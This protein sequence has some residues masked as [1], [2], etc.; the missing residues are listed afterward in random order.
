[1][2]ISKTVFLEKDI[3]QRRLI[4]EW[5]NCKAV[6][7]VWPFVGSDWEYM[8]EQIT[9]A[10]WQ[11]L[12][13]IS[14]HT[15]VWAVLHSSIDQTEWLKKRQLLKITNAK[16]IDLN[17]ND[18]W[19]RDYGPLTVVNGKGE[20]ILADFRFNGWGEKFDAKLDDSFCQHLGKLENLTYE[21][22]NMVLE[23]GAI[24]SNG[25][26]LLLMNK[27]CVVDEK[28]NADYSQRRIEKIIRQQLNHEALWIEGIGL[29]GDDTDGHIDTIARFCNHNTVIY[30]GR[31]TQH[32]DSDA[33]QS[34]H[35]QIGR[36]AQQKNWNLFE[37]PTPVLKS[38]FE[39]RF[40]PATYTNFLVCNQQ[41]FFPIYNCAEDQ[42]ALTIA[43][44]A[45]PNHKVI[46]MDCLNLLEESGSLHCATMQLTT[47]NPSPGVNYE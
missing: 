41:V 22:H 28:R 19:I 38:Q 29:T 31:N 30:S 42:L 23:G 34:L 39:D 27:D 35:E 13:T 32:H 26:G 21:T 25:Q 40:L 17:V 37:L 7:L 6:L 16:I 9:E 44:K 20:S 46:A 43:K 4:P 12:K 15:E 3:S 1:M 47:L 2:T 5:A 36:H 33:L 24:E 18:T 11:I 10:Y 8:L 14:E 45:F